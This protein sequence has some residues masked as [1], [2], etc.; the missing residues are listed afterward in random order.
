MI[1]A[2]HVSKSFGNKTVISDLSFSVAAGEVVGLLG[3][4]GSGKTTMVRLLSGVLRPDAGSVSVNGL[5]PVGDGEAVRLATGVLTESADFYRNMSALDNMRFFADLY[6]ITD[7]ERPAE[8]LQEFG[9]AEDLHRNV[10]TFSTGMRKRLGLAKAL[11]HDP[12]ALF[13]DEPTNGLDPDGTRMVLESIR[14]LN[15]RKPTTILICS[16][17]LQQLELV[18]DRYVFIDEGRLIESGTLS[19][20][21]HKYQDGVIL[22]VE[23]DLPHSAGSFAGHAFE[24]L[25]S[26]EEQRFRFRLSRRDEVPGLLRSLAND[27]RLFGAEIREQTLEDLYFQIRQERLS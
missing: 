9:L 7:R 17:L 26:A 4:N 1:D 10:G 2:T 3:P 14:R 23:A 22:D 16:H 6:D 18:C 20:L 12:P 11:L 19:E 21:R 8:L 25:Y 5:D 13:L 27:A 15:T 24:L